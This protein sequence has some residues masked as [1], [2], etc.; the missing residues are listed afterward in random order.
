MGTAGK[1]SEPMISTA[2]SRYLKQFLEILA[3]KASIMELFSASSVKRI[4]FPCNLTLSKTNSSSIGLMV[5][6]SIISTLP[7]KFLAAS[8]AQ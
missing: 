4:H 3:P 2:A 6:K 8:F 5:L 7:S 1:S